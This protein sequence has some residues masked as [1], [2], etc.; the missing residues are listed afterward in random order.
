MA[1]SWASLTP[2]QL[3]DLLDGPAGK[4]PAGVDSNTQ[5][6]ENLESVIITVLV[7]TMS[8]TVL[9]V[10]TR[11]YSKIRVMHSFGLED[12]ELLPTLLPMAKD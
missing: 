12:C 3:N 9:A 10:T 8:I 2:A 5:N 1:E 6:P 4:P 7:V 11:L